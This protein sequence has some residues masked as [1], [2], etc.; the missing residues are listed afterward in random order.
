MEIT[1]HE[2]LTQNGCANLLELQQAA[3]LMTWKMASKNEST[4][5]CHLILKIDIQVLWDSFNK[6]TF[7]SVTSYTLRDY[8]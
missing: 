8:K 6:N 4:F 2:A 7:A 5:A 3:K 1:Y